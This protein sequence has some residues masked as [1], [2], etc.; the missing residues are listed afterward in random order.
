MTVS[1]CPRTSKNSRRRPS[2]VPLRRREHPVAPRLEWLEDRVTPSLY[3]VTSLGDSGAGAGFSG[4]LRYCINAADSSGQSATI[5]FSLVSGPQT[6]TLTQPLTIAT[7]ANVT[8]DGSNAAVTISG[9]GVT[10]LFLVNSGIVEFDDLTLANG[11]GQFGGA[12]ENSGNLTLVNCSLVNNRAVGSAGASTA[13]SSGGAGGG[14]AGLGGAIYNQSYLALVDSTLSSNQAIGGNG[15]SVSGGLANVDGGS[16]GGLLGGQGGAGDA[17]GQP[18][19]SGAMGG[20]GGGGGG[21]G[22]T[23]GSGNQP[24]A[25]LGGAGGFGGGGGGGGASPLGYGSAQGGIGGVFGGMGSSA[26]I[27]YAGVGGGGAGLGGAIFNDN[28][29]LLVTNS[30]IADNSVSGGLAGTGGY[31]VAG[32]GSG[33]G[34]GLFNNSGSVILNNDTIADNSATTNGSAFYNYVASSGSAV[35]TSKVSP[36]TLSDTIVAGR[37]DHSDVYI[38]ALVNDGANAMVTATMNGNTPSNV[39]ASGIVNNGGSFNGSFTIVTAPSVVFGSNKLAN[40]GGK[41]QTILAIASSP[42]VGMGATILGP[43]LNGYAPDPSKWTTDTAVFPDQNYYDAITSNGAL[44]LADGAF[45]TTRAPVDPFAQPIHI[46]GSWQFPAQQP[47]TL[48]IITRSDGTA[49]REGSG[50]VANGIAFL[51]SDESNTLQIVALGDYSVSGNASIPFAI[52]PNDV[53]KFDVIDDGSNLTFTLT[54]QAFPD[55]SATVT[56]TCTSNLGTNLITI[57]DNHSFQ[58]E[59]SPQPSILSNLTITNAKTGAALLVDTF[60]Q[61][62]VSSADQR[63]VARTPFGSVDIGASES[64]LSVVSPQGVQTSK[65]ETPSP[66]ELGRFTDSSAA[67]PWNVSVSWGDGSPNTVFQLTSQGDLGQQIHAYPRL[68]QF[69]FVVT[70]TDSNNDSTQSLMPGSIQVTQATPTVT[71]SDPSGSFAQAPFVATANIAGAIGSPGPA[72]EG[73]GLTISYYFGAGATNSP[74][75][76]APTTVGTYTVLVTFAGSLDYQP[77]SATAMFTISPAASTTNVSAASGP[78]T[79]SPFFANETVTGVNGSAFP[80]LEGVGATVLYYSGSTKAGNILPYAPVSAGTYTATATFPG[81]QDYL[82][83]SAVTTFT[84][85]KATPSIAVTDA[86]GTY[87][88][89]PFL[90]SA[91]VTGVDGVS[92][93]TLEGVG[94]TLAYF[95]GKSPIG[96]PLPAAPTNVGTYTVTVGFAGSADYNSNSVN[97]TFTVTKATPSVKV[98]VAGSSFTGSSTAVSATVAGV[99]RQYHT[100]LEGVGLTLSYFSGTAATGKPLAASPTNAGT[101]TV[102]ATFPGSANYSAS[103]GNSTFTIGKATP[104]VNVVSAGGT[105]NGLP[106]PATA[107]VAGVKSGSGA[108]LEGVGLTFSYFTGSAA[109]G[110]PLPSAPTNAGTYTV[111]ATFPGSADYAP[112][113]A[114]KSFVIAQATPILSIVA[115]GTFTGLPLPTTVALTGVSK[116]MTATLDGSLATLTYYSGTSAVGTHVAGPPVNVGTYTVV[117]SFSSPNYRATSKSAVFTIDQA[118]Q[119]ISFPPPSPVFQ[120]PGSTISL[121]GFASSTSGLPITYTLLPTSTGTGK[122][123]KGALFVQQLGSFDIQASQPGN[124]NYQPAAPVKQ[125]LGVHSPIV[126]APMKDHV[127]NVGSD[128]VF[129]GSFTDPGATQLSITANYG[130][131]T[132]ET[133]A[134][135]SA[136]SFTLHHVYTTEGSYPVTFTAS[137]E[138]GGSGSVSVVDHVLIQQVTNYEVDKVQPGQTVTSSTTDGIKIVEATL[139]HG[140]S[141]G[142]AASLL[143]AIIPP[144]VVDSYPTVF[145]ISALTASYSYDV[146]A[147]NVT[148]FDQATVT[149]T[150]PPNGDSAPSLTFFDLGSESIQQVRGSLVAP[151]SYVVNPD[152]RTVSVVLD[153]TSFPRLQQLKGTLFTV[154]VD[155]TPISVPRSTFFVTDPSS[156]VSSQSTAP[157]STTT[158]TTKPEVAVSTLVNVLLSTDS[159]SLTASAQSLLAASVSATVTATVQNVV[160]TPVGGS[161]VSTSQD[162]GTSSLSR[163]PLEYLPPAPASANFLPGVTISPSEP[164]FPPAEEKPA[165]NTPTGK[166]TAPPNIEDTPTDEVWDNLDETCFAEQLVMVLPKTAATPPTNSYVVESTLSSMLGLGLLAATRP[167]P[168]R[169][170]SSSYHWAIDG[171]FFSIASGRLR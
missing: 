135:G 170:N 60:G 96:T 30:T 83:S 7:P 75:P 105:F 162:R 109:T 93:S 44:Q 91:V 78:Y 61:Y 84:I 52:V 55:L 98:S 119:T 152:S 24:P 171:F 21:G 37:L 12:I 25:G 112:S 86:G 35:G 82:P 166:E 15:G 120:N 115:G 29:T 95:A 99:D 16:G 147:Y 77:A 108:T 141:N 129:S 146:R 4:D 80:S 14:G 47:D 73:I 20:E 104:Q 130:D 160:G 148:P 126:F 9:N 53:Y 69:N 49:D 11:F 123:D 39:V 50:E 2:Q 90:A 169:A 139:K 157:S 88:G 165:G 31:A 67:G 85:G 134:L 113:S 116:E 19:M 87:N 145:N 167:E 28:G 76:G 57:H 102:V 54:S 107:T 151:N 101:Y 18:G 74:L 48:H 66:L 45:L 40:N 150:F 22:G 124:Q 56:A 140:T 23:V 65:Y 117:A 38:A 72:L 159:S 92:N 100:T 6:I 97:L 64:A 10:Q 71:V 59:G 103:S 125:T 17:T 5:Q 106:V 138:F 137:D 79:G 68:G 127:D 27:V 1:H 161:Q 142:Q 46:T 81:S 168:R 63:G 8:I 94:L 34:G 3:T 132:I 163:S 58:E 13:N 153:Q 155:L 136:T 42:T 156:V 111:V 51:A 62:S 133:T 41:T 164:Y 158:S 154:S 118:Q 144:T 43:A 89:V 121:D 26:A 32:D 33:A 128:S 143:V 70:V 122:I 110:A 131:S 36:V 114:S 149:F